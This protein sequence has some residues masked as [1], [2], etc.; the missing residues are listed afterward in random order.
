LF[1]ISSEAL[2]L[3]QTALSGKLKQKTREA[4]RTLSDSVEENLSYGDKVE[5]ILIKNEND[6]S[7]GNFAAGNTDQRY[8]PA[9]FS[10]TDSLLN[11]GDQLENVYTARAGVWQN[12]APVVSEVGRI[13]NELAWGPLSGD[14]KTQIRREFVTLCEKEL[15][16]ER[17]SKEIIRLFEESAWE[18]CKNELQ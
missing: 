3:A 16:E 7:N 4:M 17:L 5:R 2:P 15:N 1:S 10:V 11:K 12:T 18:E 13:H 8:L 6:F 9:I 14:E